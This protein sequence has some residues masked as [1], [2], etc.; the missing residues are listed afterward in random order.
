[1]RAY[2][3]SVIKCSAA[4]LMA[5]SLLSLGFHPRIWFLRFQ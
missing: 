5:C 2:N 3:N 4:F 1:M